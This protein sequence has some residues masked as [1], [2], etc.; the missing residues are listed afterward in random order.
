VSKEFRVG[1]GLLGLGKGTASGAAAATTIKALDDICLKID[2]GETLAVVG[3]SGSGKSTLGR[4]LLRL[5]EPSS[6]KVFFDDAELTSMRGEELRKF[7][8][9]IQIVF[10]DPYTSL[11]PRMRVVDLVRE[12]LDIFRIGTTHERELRAVEM[13]ELVG[14]RHELHSKFPNEL[15]GG[16]RQRVAIC[17][18]L[19]LRPR[20]LIA[21]EPTS[22]LDS[23]TRAQII[24]L[25]GDFKERLDLTFLLITHDMSVAR[26]VSDKVAIMYRGSIVEYGSTESIFENPQ[27]PYT[28]LLMASVPI[29]DPSKRL[30]IPQGYRDELFE[31]YS[32][33]CKF[34]GRCP[35]AEDRCRAAVPLLEDV[36][37]AGEGDHHEVACFVKPWVEEKGRL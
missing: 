5:L 22:A 23:S 33:G 8:K 17:R 11:N 1:S 10:Q 30:A 27:H 28:R 7:R 3:E 37:A 6:G 18:A 9:T 25:L 2:A 35:Y 14:L 34:A 13:L 4:V 31:T 29:P 32:G 16:E 26:L 12:P 24:E 21:D 19:I 20:F 15:S 36:G